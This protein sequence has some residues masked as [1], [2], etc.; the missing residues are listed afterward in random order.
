M[1]LPLTNVIVTLDILAETV[2]MITVSIQHVPTMVNV[3][4]DKI[5]THVSVTLVIWDVIVNTPTVLKINVK[6]VQ[7][8]SMEIQPI[9]VN[10]TMVL[11]EIIVKHGIIVLLICVTDMELV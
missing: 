11:L 3:K 10:V 2:N 1:K 5:P 9:H 6:M 4:V 7:R 8:V